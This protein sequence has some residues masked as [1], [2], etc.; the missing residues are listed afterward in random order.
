MEG[1]LDVFKWTGKNDYVAL[2]EPK[3]LSF[4]GGCVYSP[5]LIHAN[6]QSLT[7]MADTVYTLTTHSLTALQP[8]VPVSKTNCCVPQA[9]RGVMF[10]LSVLGWKCGGWG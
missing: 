5:C 2:C 7:E 3:Y 6:S 4:G 9:Q 8:A 1:K 10:H